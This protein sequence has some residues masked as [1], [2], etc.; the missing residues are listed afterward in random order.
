MNGYVNDRNYQTSNDRVYPTTPSTFPHPVFSP[1]RGPSTNDYLGGQ[2]QS[3][4][5]N[6]YGAGANGGYFP[7]TQF[8][9]QYGQSQ[10]TQYSSQY[11]QQ[12]MQSPQPAFSQRQGG[13]ATNDPTTGLARQFSNQ[14]LGSNQ[15]QTSPYGRQPSPNQR[16]RTGGATSQQNYGNHLTL[17]IPGNTNA[18]QSLSSQDPPEQDPN[19]YSDNISKKV[20]GFGLF[21]KEWFKTKAEGTRDRN[22]R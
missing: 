7:N 14:N 10:Q 19:K 4:N 11:Q 9:S 5:T 17:P 16:P 20:T 18:S 1:L 21:I 2:V 6:G 15:R 22:E 12:N 13:Y 3:P 8:Q